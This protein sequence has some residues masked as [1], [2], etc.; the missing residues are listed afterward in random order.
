M[1]MSRPNV[2]TKLW[3]LLVFMCLCTACGGGRDGDGFVLI[4]DAQMN[5]LGADAFEEIKSSTPISTNLELTKKVVEIGQKIAAASEANFDWEFVLF[6]SEQVN[7]FCLPGGKIGVYEGILPVAENNAGLAAIMGHEVAHAILRH[8]AEKMSAG[9]VAKAGFAVLSIGLDDAKYRDEIMAGLGLGY[10]VG[11]SLPFGRSQESEADQIG[12]EY[13]AKAGYDPAE[14][15]GL[16]RRMA[17]I[18]SGTPAILSTH[19]DPSE[20]AT[21][22]EKWQADVK[23]VYEASEKVATEKL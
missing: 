18:S 23:Q 3:F 6:A 8:S 12:L 1:S 4:P 22:L 17:A 13:M 10:Q 19:P 2:V 15:P 16:W 7:A 20:R 11:I 14:A 21:D 5:S 9:I